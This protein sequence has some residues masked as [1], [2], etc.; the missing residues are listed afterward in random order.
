MRELNTSDNSPIRPIPNVC[1]LYD[2]R[3]RWE[4]PCDTITHNSPSFL[5]SILPSPAKGGLEG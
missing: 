1:A 5:L 2:W 4:L 3:A